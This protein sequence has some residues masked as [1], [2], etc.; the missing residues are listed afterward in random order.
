M[1]LFTAVHGPWWDKD[2][3]LLIG[4]GP[5]LTGFDLARFVGRPGHRVIGVNHAMFDLPDCDAGVS[6]DAAFIETNHERLAE[7]ASRREL[8]L[9]PGER[10][11][12]VGRT[13]IP[14]A[15]YLRPADCT[16]LSLHPGWVCNGGT[17][18]YTALNVAVL[19][20]ATVIVLFGYDYGSI[21]ARH[22]YHNRYP[23]DSGCWQEWAAYYRAAKLD[24]AKA[25]VIV[26]NASIDSAI[27][28][29][30]KCS[31]EDALCDRSS[32]KAWTASATTFTSG[33][34]SGSF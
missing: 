10:W 14:G 11:F 2:R 27:D 1:E 34:P 32:S 26:I 6:R 20:R 9:A 29:F 28:A 22:H 30:P 25:G 33:R 3:V 21:G 4:G 13:P 15:V 23:F 16:G 12:E 7:F 24:C 31:I 8:Y 5:S 17:S 18:G 19:K